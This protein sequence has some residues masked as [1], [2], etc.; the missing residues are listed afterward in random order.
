MNQTDVYTKIKANVMAKRAEQARIAALAAEVSRGSATAEQMAEHRALQASAQQ[1]K[2]RQDAVLK[3]H[4]A[5][6]ATARQRLI[7][8]VGA[9][10]PLVDEF[11]SLKLVEHFRAFCAKH[12]LAD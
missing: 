9:V 11:D 12:K 5:A 3:A 1:V 7:D 4:K 8:A 6:H 10:H 2:D